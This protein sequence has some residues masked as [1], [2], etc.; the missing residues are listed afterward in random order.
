MSNFSRAD[1]YKIYNSHLS[2]FAELAQYAQ[3]SN[4]DL[5]LD[6][7]SDGTIALSSKDWFIDKGKKVLRKHEIIQ[8]K[9]RV[10]ERTAT[11]TYD[12]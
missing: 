2:L 10:E 11:F 4:I 9:D 6:I 1:L 12:T 8:G 3:G 7:S 5:A